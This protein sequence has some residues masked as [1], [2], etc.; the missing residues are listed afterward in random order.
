MGLGGMSRA[1][2]VASAGMA[3]S[4][5]CASFLLIGN[6]SALTLQLAGVVKDWLLIVMSAFVFRH[7]LTPLNLGGYG[8]AFL[9]VCWYNLSKKQEERR[10]GPG[11]VGALSPARPAEAKMEDASD[12]KA[13]QNGHAL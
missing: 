9:G 2:A 1:T 5:N 10:E 7:A 3:F 8:V 12:P 11:L 13:Q 6:T 4:L